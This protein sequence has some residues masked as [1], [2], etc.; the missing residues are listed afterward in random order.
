MAKLI[1]AK[2]ENALITAQIHSALAFHLLMKC[3]VSAEFQTK[4]GTMECLIYCIAYQYTTQN[5]F[6]FFR[7]I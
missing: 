7:I 3:Y 5:S 4:F 1:N 2:T 6:I